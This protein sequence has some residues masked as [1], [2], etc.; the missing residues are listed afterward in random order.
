MNRFYL[1]FL[2][3]SFIYNSQG[4]PF[5]N[6][7]TTVVQIDGVVF[8]LFASGDE[9]F[10][11]LHDAEGFTIVLGSDGFYY[12]GERNEHGEIVSSA[13]RYGD[14]NPEKVGL[15]RNVVV[16]QEKYNE[17]VA[18][19][20]SKFIDIGK[21]K[22]S[23][24]YRIQKQKVENIYFNNI[25]IFITFP[26][27]PF[28]KYDKS[29]YTSIFNGVDQPSLKSYYE[30]VSYGKLDVNSFFFPSSSVNRYSYLA[31]HSRTY[32]QAFNE[33]TNPYG[34]LNDAQRTA[35]E[36]G[37]LANAIRS[38]KADIESVMSR[39]DLDFDDDGFVDNICFVI[40]GNSDGWSDL[41]WAHRWS[42]YSENVKIHDK[43]VYTYVFQ[44]ENQVN[45]TTLCHEMFHAFGAPDLYHYNES[46]SSLNPV[47]DWDLMH[48]GAGHMGAYM[49]YKY[50]G[51]INDI[52]EITTTGVYTLKPLNGK[53]SNNVCYKIKSSRHNEYYVLEYRRKNG[54]YDSGVYGSGLVIYRINEN[55]YPQGNRN[56]PPDEVYVYRPYGTS[57]SN[58]NI[59]DSF[60]S[61]ESN[62]KTFGG[63]AST[64]PFLSDG[65]DG[66]LRI[67]NISSAGEHIS[68][69]IARLPNI[70]TSIKEVESVL[71]VVAGNNGIFVR[72][73]KTPSEILVY[74]LKGVLIS[75][76]YIEQGDWFISVPTSGVYVVRVNN[77]NFKIIL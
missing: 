67:K 70:S 56:G 32:Y 44:P 73:I 2:L 20:N 54:M 16:S 7:K 27:A 43:K 40:Q 19:F 1:L 41:L 34:Y 25:V 15:H 61:L 64:N 13:Y 60:F 76:K 31:D 5:K 39:E 18:M 8:E 66:L 9:Y 71:S 6:L 65:Q 17:K 77:S 62:R 3:F 69:E 42:L 57:I 75:K 72:N 45:V 10:S 46:S 35:R 37:L 36:H 12:Y 74:D 58:G 48:S 63:T 47:G 49:K 53:S 52:P 24:L 26:D 51:W 11:R 28:L 30:E 22:G 59:N 23:N 68:F 50:G 29:K 38:L 21:D 33:T 4:A 14:V 55:I